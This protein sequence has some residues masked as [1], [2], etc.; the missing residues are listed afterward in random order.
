MKKSLTT[1]LLFILLLQGGG[2]ML[3]LLLQQNALK[4]E[5]HSKMERGEVAY[6]HITLS[7][8]AYKNALVEKGEI[9][10][11]G[12]LFDIHSEIVTNDKVTLRVVYDEDEDDIIHEIK[13]YVR[14]NCHNNKS[15]PD[16][17]VYLFSMNFIG[18]SFHCSNFDLYSCELLFITK[19]ILFSNPTDEVFTPPPQ[20]I[21]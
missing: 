9:L 3:L 17:S 6:E 15:L 16:S 4:D 12:K 19:R 14:R 5:M 8:A 20:L 2:F 10:I 18:S 13:K 21:A 1:V 11:D 7:V